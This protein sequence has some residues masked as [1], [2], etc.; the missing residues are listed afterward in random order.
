MTVRASSAHG[1]GTKKNGKSIYCHF[2]GF[3]PFCIFFSVALA[4]ALAQV[5]VVVPVTTSQWF[6]VGNLPP[7][8][9]GLLRLTV[10]GCT[11]IPTGSGLSGCDFLVS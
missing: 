3:V 4:Q 7:R 6:L 5:V 9:S 10:P 8:F 11:L 1:M 2:D